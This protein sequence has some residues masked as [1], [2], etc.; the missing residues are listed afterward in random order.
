MNKINCFTKTIVKLFFYTNWAACMVLL[1]N[2]F[3]ELY[4]KGKLIIFDS[5]IK[6]SH[7]QPVVLD[8]IVVSYAVAIFR[9]IISRIFCKLRFLSFCSHGCPVCSK[10]P[11]ISPIT[12][13]FVALLLSHSQHCWLTAAFFSATLPICF[14]CHLSLPR[15]FCS[16]FEFGVFGIFHLTDSCFAEFLI[17]IFEFLLR[18]GFNRIY[19]IFILHIISIVLLN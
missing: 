8:N 7:V 17:T 2:C 11:C 12:L 4:L 19:Y 15:R 18:P 3:I 6:Y 14:Q 13:Q 10:W 16:F 1:F 9:R 5:P